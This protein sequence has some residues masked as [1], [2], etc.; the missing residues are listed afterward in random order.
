MFTSGIQT[1]SVRRTHLSL[2]LFKAGKRWFIFATL[3]LKHHL[4]LLENIFYFPGEKRTFVASSFLL[5]HCLYHCQLN[6]F[7]SGLAVAQNELFK[8]GTLGSG[9]L[10][11][12]FLIKIFSLR[13]FW[14]LEMFLLW[15]SHDAERS[16]FVVSAHTRC[17][18]I[19]FVA[20]ELVEVWAAGFMCIHGKVWDEE[21]NKVVERR[22]RLKNGVCESDSDGSFPLEGHAE[23]RILPEPLGLPHAQKQR[24]CLALV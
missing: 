8:C 15:M 12:F 13:I 9:S 16:G 21:V 11:P 18:K 24:R 17:E 14:T 10:W 19:I 6:I 22:W 23:A 4:N 2:H 20:E 1:P 7:G 5:F 3:H